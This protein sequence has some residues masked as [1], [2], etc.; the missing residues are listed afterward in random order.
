MLVTQK[1]SIFV[2]YASITTGRHQTIAACLP[3][4]PLFL[5]SES[6]IGR[7]SPCWRTISRFHRLW[8]VV[9]VSKTK[10]RGDGET[11]GTA[12]L[13]GGGNGRMH[14]I[15]KSAWR[16][17]VNIA[18]FVGYVAGSPSIPLP[19]PYTYPAFLP[20]QSDFGRFGCVS[21]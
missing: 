21:W 2:V 20:C 9:F 19:F 15:G 5:C 10:R 6:G 7:S 8:K 14:G 17:D 1:I 16:L 12:E 3:L 4:Q 13:S 18:H 11:N